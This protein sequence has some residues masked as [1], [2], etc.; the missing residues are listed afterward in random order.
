M[1]LNAIKQKAIEQDMTGYLLSTQANRKY[2]VQA[3][4]DL[5]GQKIV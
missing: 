5:K 3:L 2:S 1:M 4:E